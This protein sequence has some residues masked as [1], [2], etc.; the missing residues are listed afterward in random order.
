MR[1]PHSCCFMHF[2]LPPLSPPSESVAL[3]KGSKLS[4]AWPSGRTTIVS[5]RHW[6]NDTDGRKS[7]SRETRSSVTLST[8]NTIWADPS[9]NPVF[10]NE[11]SANSD[12]DI[13]A[14]TLLQRSC[15]S[16]VS[17]T[18]LSDER[19]GLPLVRVSYVTLSYTNRRKKILSQFFCEHY[20]EKQRFIL[21]YFWRHPPGKEAMTSVQLYQHSFKTWPLNIHETRDFHLVWRPVSRGLS[22]QAKCVKFRFELQYKC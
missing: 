9:L 18:A 5:A 19:A 13:E 17:R 2:S 7:K 20:P 4:S 21:V 1:K 8:I 16:L 22:F 6:W 14:F 15:E 3:L 11:N 10:C 12:L